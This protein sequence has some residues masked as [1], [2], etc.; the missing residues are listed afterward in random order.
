MKQPA[1]GTEREG[2]VAHAQ[3]SLAGQKFMIME[4]SAPEHDFKFNEAASIIVNCHNQKEIDY[5]WDKL[6]D[7]G[8]G[9]ACGWL[10][11]KFGVAWQVDS[12]ELSQML[13][14]PDKEKVGRVTNA[15][16]HMKKF[17]LAKLREAFEGSVVAH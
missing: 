5:Y 13:K 10:K 12:V 4:S 15:F 3:F 9:V 6:T 11:D 2:T 17:D 14:D 8:E 1:G 7:G 16:L